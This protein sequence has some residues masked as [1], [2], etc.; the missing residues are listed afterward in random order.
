MAANNVIQELELNSVLPWF[1]ET[2]FG[3]EKRLDRRQF[4]RWLNENWSLSLY[5]VG[6][7]LLVIAGLSRWMR[8]KKRYEVKGLL[9]FWNLGLALFSIFASVRL[10][11]EFVRILSDQGGCHKSI[12]DIR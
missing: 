2:P 1:A 7:Y 12:C 11:P 5:F 6:I 9:V 3:F 10:I 8:Q 4:Y